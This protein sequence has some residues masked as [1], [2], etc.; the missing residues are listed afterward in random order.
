M[1]VSLDGL[2]RQLQMAHIGNSW[3]EIVEVLHGPPDPARAAAATNSK[4]WED[5]WNHAPALIPNKKPTLLKWLEQMKRDGLLKRLSGDRPQQAEAWLEQACSVLQEAPLHN[6]PLAKVAA[7]FAGNSHALDSDSPLATVILR[8]IAILQGL[9][10]PTSAAERRTLWSKAGIVCDEL[11]A[12]VLTFN[13][14]LDSAY[15]LTE[16]LDVARFAAVP[17]HLSTR[18]LLTTEWRSVV[19]PKRVYVCENA[20]VIAFVVR[21]LGSASAPLVCVDGEP[22]TA[23]WLLLEHLREAGSELFYHGDFDWKGAA[24]AARVMARA[25]AKPWRYS[26]EDYVAAPGTEL[27]KGSPIP[28]PWCPELARAMVQ[29]KVA[30]HEEALADLLLTDLRAE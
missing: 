5:L 25:G 14:S 19:G 21:W 11:S 10:M 6:E 18:L 9:S 2:L 16:L 20:S 13:L 17:L 7:R 3:T 27:L 23:G 8:A 12:P 28:T 30:I 29:R 22:K 1:R 24:I 15:P 26:A 4:A